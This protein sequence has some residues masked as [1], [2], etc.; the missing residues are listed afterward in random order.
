MDQAYYIVCADCNADEDLHEGFNTTA[1][2]HKEQL[3]T[4]LREES[5]IDDLP[6]LTDAPT[7]SYN[8][9]VST[10]ADLGVPM[11]AIPKP[12]DMEIEMKKE[13]AFSAMMK[14]DKT[15]LVVANG[16]K[17]SKKKVDRM[18]SGSKRTFAELV[19][20]IDEVDGGSSKKSR[21]SFG[22]Y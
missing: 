16:A 18:G 7:G 10:P 2:Y 6:S 11:L 22:G 21:P 3:A 1:A 15:R 4:K 19:D 5:K 13:N 12:E 17:K 20:E 8:S 14:V 9:E